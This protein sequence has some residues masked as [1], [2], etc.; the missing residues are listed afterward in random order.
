MLNKFIESNNGQHGFATYMIS[1]LLAISALAFYSSTQETASMSYGLVKD[2][3]AD[4]ENA[5]GIGPYRSIGGDAELCTNSTIFSSLKAVPIDTGPFDGA[6]YPQ[7]KLLF[8]MSTINILTPGATAP[9]QFEGG[10]NTVQ[11]MG[12]QGMD[13]RQVGSVFPKNFPNAPRR[14]W[15]RM[16]YRS[17]VT[18]ATPAAVATSKTKN[19]EKIAKAKQNKK[20]LRS[21]LEYGKIDSQDYIISAENAED[22]F[23]E[24]ESAG[25]PTACYGEI[26]SRNYCISIGGRYNVNAPN[27]TPRCLKS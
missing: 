10:F 5:R 23:V 14:V 8:S 13:V 25:I 1:S 16:M 3:I 20:P 24:L 27:G 21:W 15:L 18:K 17:N 19:D 2:T 22:L 12:I 7:G 4:P 26:S 9:V 6:L 11:K